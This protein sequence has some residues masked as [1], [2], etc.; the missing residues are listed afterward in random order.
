MDVDRIARR[1]RR[2]VAGSTSA[3][4]R[5]TSPFAP[6]VAT[7]SVSGRVRRRTGDDRGRRTRPAELGDALRRGVAVVVR[8]GGRLLELATA[9]AGRKVG[10]PEAEVDHVLAGPTE[11]ER[12]LPDHGET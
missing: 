6:I 12:Q 4:I 10:V 7:T 5:W 11:L 3:H 2:G 9:T 1:G 8:L